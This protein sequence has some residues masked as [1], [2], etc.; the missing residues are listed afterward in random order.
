M[1]TDRYTCLVPVPL[2]PVRLRDRGFNQAE[3]LAERLLHHFPHARLCHDLRRIR[4]TRVQSRIADPKDR[5]TNVRGAFAVDPSV[6]LE[7]ERVLLI[8]DVVTTGG[9]VSEC[10]QALK[11]AGAEYV[12]VLAF[13]L[14]VHQPT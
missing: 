12:D 9:T 13:A 4:P 7:G 14:T 5:E 3:L 1:T 2:H 8:D 10:A 11:R 6:S